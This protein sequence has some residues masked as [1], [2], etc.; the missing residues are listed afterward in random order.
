MKN[1]YLLARLFV[2][3]ALGVVP[4]LLGVDLYLSNKTETE[5]LATARDSARRDDLV[6]IPARSQNI[7]IENITP[8][9]TL[10]IYA[11]SQDKPWGKFLITLG[12]QRDERINLVI[13]EV[14]PGQFRL[15]DPL[16][17]SGEGGYSIQI[18]HENTLP[19]K[20]CPTK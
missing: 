20:D 12:G 16:N 1:N 9:D 4:S 11:A 8:S 19:A 13:A 3:I 10:T 6:R 14:S 5:M 18:L 7:F 15:Q 17:E 2:C